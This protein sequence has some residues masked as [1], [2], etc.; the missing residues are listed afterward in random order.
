MFE[1]KSYIK[2]RGVGKLNCKPELTLE[3]VHTICVV[4]EGLPFSTVLDDDGNPTGKQVYLP[5][6]V[7]F[8]FYTALVSVA[9][10]YDLD[11][12]DLWTDVHS[13]D[14][15]DKLNV[16]YADYMPE[17]YAGAMDRIARK[18]NALEPV[19]EAA[20]FNGVA[21]QLEGVDIG[22]ILTLAKSISDMDGK[23]IVKAA[24]ENSAP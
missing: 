13:T 18:A 14:L 4:A 19:N 1:K 8:S 23:E 22:D 24:L 12:R 3:D 2:V 15:I 20:L 11:A 10:D 6:A 5:E 7:E 17:M 16:Y 9:T 21:K